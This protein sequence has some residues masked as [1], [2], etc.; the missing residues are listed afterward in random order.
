[1]AVGSILVSNI[2]NIDYTERMSTALERIDSNSLQKGEADE[3][4]RI[5]Q[6][7]SSLVGRGG[8][9]FDLPDSLT[10]LLIHAAQAVRLGRSVALISEKEQLTT[11]EAADYM[12]VSRPFLIG[13]LQK[14]Q[15]PFHKVGA[16]RRIR[17]TDLRAYEGQRNLDRRNTLDE[18]FDSLDREGFYEL[19]QDSELG[20][21]G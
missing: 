19:G 20:E 14:G 13:L 2:S 8:E 10:R 11:Q 4:L 6:S 5:L 17:F 12:G 16:H 9:R 21:G 15:I 1:M 18:L 7:G 3:L